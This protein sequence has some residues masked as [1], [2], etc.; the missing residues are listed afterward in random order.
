MSKIGK[1]P[2]TIN[3]DVQLNVDEQKVMVKG[4]KGEGSVTLPAGISAVL[5]N[6][7][8]FVRKNDKE[9]GTD[10]LHGLS[11]TL[12]ANLV[13]GVKEPW[14]KVLEIHGVGYRAKVE[15]KEV[16]F[17]VGYSHP[18][19]FSI[20]EGI[21]V[22]IKGNKV[23]VRGI[24][25]QFVGETAAKMKAIRKPD[26]YKGKGIRYQGEVL[27]LKPGKKAKAGA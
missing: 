5:E 14:E 4:P 6:G 3:Q 2:I 22:E 24:D 1:V 11:R 19:K 13:Q 23:Y 17:Q 10:A 27:K 7:Q 20:P 16:V 26:K 8:L 9:G 12:V 25:R 21:Q 18:V 15:G